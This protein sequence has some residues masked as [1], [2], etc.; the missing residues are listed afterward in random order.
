MTCCFTEIKKLRLVIIQLK[1]DLNYIDFINT[2]VLF[3]I[4]HTEFLAIVI[5]PE[6]KA[7]QIR[8]EEVNCLFTDNCR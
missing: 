2:L 7:I 5:R 4:A 6:I 1:V 3:N 8:K